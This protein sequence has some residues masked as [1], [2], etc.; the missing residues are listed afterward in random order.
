M[1]PN[2]QKIIDSCEADWDA[3][4]GD[5]NKFARAAAA[6]VGVAL[7]QGT[8]DAIVDSITN[9][10]EWTAVADGV[11]AKT[12]ADNGQF[13]VAGLKAA[14]HNPP[15]ANG[16]V[17]IVTS[18]PLASGKYPTG[19]WGSL[20]GT[21]YKNTTLNYAWNKTDRDSIHYFFRDLP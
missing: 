16:H 8:A 1:D 19:Y 14:D 7:V 5:C 13:V 21:P 20:G 2:A 12:H 11:A 15:R 9:D 17:A 4:K 6:G 3:N 10:A 18:G